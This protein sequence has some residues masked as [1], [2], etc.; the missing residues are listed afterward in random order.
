MCEHPIIRVPSQSQTPNLNCHVAK[1]A[2]DQSYTHASKDECHLPRKIF[3]KSARFSCVFEKHLKRSLQKHTTVSTR[4]Q[5]GLGG[6]YKISCAFDSEWRTIFTFLGSLCDTEES[7]RESCA[8]MS[9]CE[10]HTHMEW[11]FSLGTEIIFLSHLTGSI[12]PQCMI[13]NF[14][15]PNHLSWS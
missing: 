9:I 11:A 7:T 15:Q 4:S 13:C 2:C 12:E 3:C 14:M 8:F 1:S 6:K 5:F 10:T